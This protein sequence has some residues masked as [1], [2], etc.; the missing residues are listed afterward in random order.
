MLAAKRSRALRVNAVS[1][2]VSIGTPS[3]PPTGAAPVEAVGV[4]GVGTFAE[5]V[6]EAHPKEQSK[7]TKNRSGRMIISCR[8]RRPPY[9]GR[10]AA[11]RLVT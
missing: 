6:V 2:E 3:L 9:H 1:D 7:R 5:R 4:A 8:A 10:L 11:R